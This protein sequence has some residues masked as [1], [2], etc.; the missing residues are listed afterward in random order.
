[1]LQ[2]ASDTLLQVTTDGQL[3][4]NGGAIQGNGDIALQARTLD[5]RD[6]TIA[7]QQSIDAVLTEALDNSGGRLVAGGD[8]TVAAGALINRDTLD[9]TGE[10]GLFGD[11]VTLDAASIDNTRGR[12]GASESLTVDTGELVNA[13]GAID[14]EGEV[15]VTA[16]TFDNTGGT[17]VQRGAGD[18]LVDVSGAISNSNDGLIGTEG[19]AI[20]R[21]GTLDNTG[22]TVL[23]RKSV[24]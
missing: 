4:N 6:G 17:L 5:N 11:N 24:V 7:T 23:D 15:V 8:L 13:A 19:G 3:L 18:L 1:M 20:L 22:G 9:G 10:R 2:A 16:A 14:G 12:I 21:A